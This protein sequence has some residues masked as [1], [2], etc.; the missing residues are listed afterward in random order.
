MMIHSILLAAALL[1]PAQAKN[2][3][4]HPIKPDIGWKEN[5]SDDKW[6]AW[7]HKESGKLYVVG[8]VEVKRGYRILLVKAHTNGMNPKTL[9]INVVPD[10]LDVP[11][12]RKKDLKGTKKMTVHFSIDNYKV[13]QYD[14]VVLIYGD[15][16]RRFID[17]DN[18]E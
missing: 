5:K 10:E 2:P 9:V 7:F 13:G 3:P 16:S 6:D 1:G 14:K 12:E 11:E 18:G 17:I 15:R 8:K 4:A